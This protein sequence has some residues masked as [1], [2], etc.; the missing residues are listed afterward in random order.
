MTGVQPLISVVTPV[1]N[2]ETY[3]AECIESVLAQTYAHWDYVL[4]DNCST[5]STRE[6]AERYAQR[7]T[8]VRVVTNPQFLAQFQNW[9]A[10]LRQMPPAARYCKVLHADDWLFPEC[11]ERMAALADA[12]PSVGVV[13]AYRLEEDRVSL[14]GLPHTQTV[15]PG[16]EIAR[17][18]LLGLLYLFGSPTSLLLRADLVRAH[19]PFYAEDRLHADTDVMYRLLHECDFGFVHQVLTFTRRHNESLTSL[20]RRLST[21]FLA[22]F[23]FLIEHGPQYLTPEELRQR[24]LEYQEH[25]YRFLAHSVFE[26]KDE[27]F[28]NYQRQELAA[29]GYPV[30]RGRLMKSVMREL[31]DLRW[32]AQLLRRGLAR[33]WNGARTTGPTAEAV[34][35]SML[36]RSAPERLAK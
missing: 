35:N 30:R 20:T 3:L 14:D 33:R 32:T 1:Y 27:E 17:R 10:A 36:N 31:A 16:R 28:W 29:L 26:L 12:N 6:I 19:D 9:N 2:G 23:R 8:R 4:V 24:M 18:S 11:L 21:H 34:L 5:D 25:Y 7:D 22:D 15:L 13:G